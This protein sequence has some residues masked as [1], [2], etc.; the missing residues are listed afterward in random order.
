MR[1]FALRA[2]VVLLLAALAVA[3]GSAYWVWHRFNAPG[4]LTAE[5]TLI[6]PK[7]VGVRAVAHE[8]RGAGVI[9]NETVFVLG[10]RYLRLG[11]HLRAGEFAFAPRMTMRAV[12]RHLVSG[13]MVLRRLTIPEGLLSAEVVKLVDNAD[14]LTG[15]VDKVP[16]DGTLL[17]ET[18][19]YSYGD[20]RESMVR[21]MQSAMDT[22]L[23][24]AWKGRAEGL[25]IRSPQEALVLASIIERETA[26]PAERPRISAVFNNRLKRG[27]RLQSDPTVAYAITGG[28]HAL[29]RPLTTA[30]LKLD[31]PYNTYERDGLPPGP[32][33]NP[34]RASL[35]AAVHPADTKDLYFVA[36]GTGGHAFSTTLREHNR[37]VA[38]WRKLEREQKSR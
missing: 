2:V 6:V 28:K 9:D 24:E 8:L 11:R 31:S 34:G 29:D 17:P 23:S 15:A 12:V 5:K 37:N 1:R 19:F 27:M 4:P 22:A 32:I 35:A 26:V 14:G 36:D 13:A 33:A 7:G 10:A 38:R 3:G 16:P 25:A 30:D 20:S 18:Y 21:R